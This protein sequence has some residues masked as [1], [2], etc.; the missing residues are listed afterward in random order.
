MTDSP[1]SVLR[2]LEEASS[3][4]LFPS[5]T[6]APLTAIELSGAHGADLSAEGLLKVLG[7]AGETHVDE[8]TPDELFAPLLEAGDDDAAKYG[9][10]LELIKKELTDVRAYRV[11]T[12][13]IDIYLIG[14]HPSGAWVG[15]QTRAVET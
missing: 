3:G 8:L 10:I 9:R 12:T 1:Q 15:L 4:L 14:K 6:D 11:G 2:A 13:D 5:E 7:R